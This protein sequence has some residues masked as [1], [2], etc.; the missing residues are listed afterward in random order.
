MKKASF[1]HLALS[2]MMIL[3]LIN[4]SSV[5]SAQEFFIN[6]EGDDANPGTRLKPFKTIAGARDK[7]RQYIRT[8]GDEDINVW[9][10]GG[11]YR[12]SGTLV[13]GLEDGAKNGHFITY[14]ALPGEKPVISSDVTVT[15]WKKLSRIPN[16]LHKMFRD[17]IWVAKIPDDIKPFNTLY[18]SRQALPRAR[19]KGFS[20][21]RKADSKEEGLYNSIP[22]N[23]DLIKEMFNPANTE[24]VVIPGYAWV[25]NIL[26]VKS[27][28]Y[29]NGMVS[30][31]A[32]STYP[33]FETRHYSKTESIWVENT[34]A[35]LDEPGEWVFDQDQHL[36][37][38]WPLNSKKPGDDIVIPRLVEMIR[39]EGKIDYNSPNDIPV[40][41]LHFKGIT[42][43]HGNRFESS[44]QTGWGLQHDWEKFDA[45][46]ALIRFRGTENCIVESC[47]F[48]NSGG[49][50]IRFDLFS[51]NNK[52]IDN[53]IYEL[54]GAGILFAGYGPGTK[55]VN[56]NNI[57]SN[58]YIHHIGRLWT[59]SLGIWLWQS[60]YN[61][62]SHNTIHDVPYSAI[63]VTGRIIWDKDG[64]GECSK[65][66]RWKEVGKF[67]GDEQWVERER[68]IH[69]R[70]NI[71]ENN[72]LH[73]VM[74]V[75]NDGNGIYISGAGKGNVVRGNFIHDTPQQG[76]GGALRCDDDQNDVLLENN[77][78]FHFNLL[79]IGLWSKGCNHFINNIV[80][81]PPDR[82][83]LG[84]L[85]FEIRD[86][87]KLCAGS[88]L[89]HNIYYAT[90]ENQPFIS[91]P[92]MDNM[93]ESI[94]TD[95]NLYYNS[96]DPKAADGYFQ[97]ARK[98]GNEAKS[99]QADPLFKD[100]ENGDF[101]LMPDS[102][103]ISMGFIP[104]KINAGIQRQIFQ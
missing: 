94:N 3:L 91:L 13:F 103:A 79:G 38:Y 66:V 23:K 19:S 10:A 82:V 5:C 12:L 77:I 18:D 102:P 29:S 72:D 14:A 48:K 68:F 30:L 22:F 75:M 25:I 95:E 100:P 96:S 52:V 67:T 26:P 34:F 87:S 86:K 39:V 83:R 85:T 36:L 45:S 47:T 71:L 90:K 43:T 62:V 89:R 61:L 59:H 56:K 41:G 6:P 99:I 101:T 57:I 84:M 33:L 40:N 32:H 55:D 37:Y 69:S 58:N 50:A 35:G 15:G 4:L 8:K 70:N 53:D 97:I 64:S 73:H 92:G 98:Y 1:H 31:G 16:G 21:L 42:F 27:V 78:I 54:G 63:A 7:V 88:V 2:C 65:T 76:G 49:T 46:T 51:Q 28:D 104:F 60:G 80:A 11:E 24:I 9:L 20:H 81:C 17:K 44:G 93:I 74:T